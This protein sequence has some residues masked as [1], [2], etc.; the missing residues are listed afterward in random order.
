M[1]FDHHQMNPISEPPDHATKLISKTFK[2]HFHQ[3]F[4]KTALLSTLYKHY[5]NSRVISFHCN[6]KLAIVR[7]SRIASV[8]LKTWHT[9]ASL[10]QPLLT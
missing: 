8:T 3:Y 2:D 10:P 5:P 1:G 4:F 6:D 9:L 7:C